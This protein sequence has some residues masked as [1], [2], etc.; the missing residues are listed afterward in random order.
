V[1]RVKAEFHGPRYDWFLE[2]LSRSWFW[3]L[4]LENS[5]LYILDFYGN[6]APKEILR[7]AASGN[8]QDGVLGALNSKS[9]S[10]ATRVVL[11][12]Y[13]WMNY[14]NF[15][16]IGTIG[17]ALG[18]DPRFFIIHFQDHHR[19]RLDT[20]RRPPSLLHLDTSV[21]QFQF[22]EDRYMTICIVQNVGRS[23]IIRWETFA[24]L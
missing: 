13:P 4:P 11:L 24:T 7:A 8:L 14:L 18:L 21:L 2:T 16:Y 6:T 1:E 12:Y 23:L 20:D 3:E 15:E 22:L 5:C 9:L 19:G 10:A 17:H